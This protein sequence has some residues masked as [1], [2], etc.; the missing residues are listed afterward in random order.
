MYPMPIERDDLLGDVRFWALLYE[1]WV[2][3]RVGDSFDDGEQYFFSVRENAVNAFF[4]ELE[5]APTE[6]GS[7]PEYSVLL[8]LRNGWRIGVVLSM[9]PED[10]A[11]L[12]AVRPPSSDEL[13]VFGVNGGNSQL[14]AL[15][16]EELLI[17]RDAVVPPEPAT[18]AKAIL[19]LFPSVCLSSDLEIGAVRRALQSAWGKTGIPIR[20]ADELVARDIDDFIENRRLHP[21]VKE[22][23]WRTHPRHGWINDSE[24]SLRNPMVDGAQRVLPVIRQLFSTLERGIDQRITNG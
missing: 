15:R 4:R 13:I 24:H 10:F 5:G 1:Y 20:H 21:D 6:A 2:K 17:I 18:K 3:P 12:D 16:W 11:V 19:L 9:Y 7:Y 23:L 22:T 8:T 14:P